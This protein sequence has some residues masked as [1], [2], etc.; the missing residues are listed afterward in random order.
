MAT[1]NK[2]SRCNRLGGYAY[3][4]EDKVCARCKNKG[5]QARSGKKDEDGENKSLNE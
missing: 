2:C 5:P 4:A 1:L 3:S